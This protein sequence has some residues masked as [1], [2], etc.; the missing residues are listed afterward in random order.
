MSSDVDSIKAKINSLTAEKVEAQADL[1][2]ARKAK[3][4]VESDLRTYGAKMD[5][6]QRNKA[7][8]NLEELRQ[9]IKRLRRKIDTLTAKIKAQEELLELALQVQTAEARATAAQE[10]AA[11]EAA[12]EVEH[13]EAAAEEPDSGKREGHNRALRDAQRRRAARQREAAQLAA[14]AA[15][16]AEQVVGRAAD[17]DDQ[18]E[19]ETPELEQPQP[20]RR[21][22]LGLG[23][24][25]AL[26]AGLLLSSRR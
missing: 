11:V 14:K 26:G 12:A 13:A 3:Q 19:Q 24:A 25:L 5:G 7:A 6:A 18:P 17:I 4:E 1:A 8:A 22:G 2:T 15:D 23:L 20:R 21:M 16:L 9:T 10:A